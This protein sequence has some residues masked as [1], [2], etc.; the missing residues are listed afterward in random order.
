[1]KGRW[2]LSV[3]VNIESDPIA[4][5]GS[6]TYEVDLAPAAKDE[7]R[8]TFT[9]TFLDTKVQG[10]VTGRVSPPSLGGVGG[11]VR[12][13]PGYELVQ[14]GEHPRLIFRKKELEG[15]RRRMETPEGQAILAMLKTR[16]PLRDPLGSG[17]T[18]RHTSWMAA[19]WGAFWQLTGALD[20]ARRARE[21]LMNE[22]ITKPM[23]GDRKE[24]H[25]ASRLLGIALTYDLCYDA[26]DEE[27]RRLVAEYIHVAALDLASGYHEGFQMSEDAFQP[28]PWGHRNAIRMACVGCAALAILGDEDSAMK[29]LASHRSVR[30]SAAIIAGDAPLQGDRRR[31]RRR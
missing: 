30:S 23:P 27:F 29:P 8:G 7:F 25:H 9:G 3:R 12:T 22:V 16:A 1:V 5:G 26:W 31:L 14:P 15:L 28:D 20:A 18:D 10:A 21:V 19:N 24:I 11:G 6:A 2:R 4:P 13:V 17:I